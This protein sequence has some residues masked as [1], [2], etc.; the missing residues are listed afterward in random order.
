MMTVHVIQEYESLAQLRK[1]KEDGRNKWQSQ[2]SRL[3]LTMKSQIA[4][5]VT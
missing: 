5:E 3:Q 1:V 4:K 2:V